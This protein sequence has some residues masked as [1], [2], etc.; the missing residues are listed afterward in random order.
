[1]DLEE[2]KDIIENNFHPD[3]FLDF[4]DIEFRDML[5]RYEDVLIEREQ[6][7]RKALR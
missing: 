5:D 3:S 4:L 1:V 2:L 6:E 7:F